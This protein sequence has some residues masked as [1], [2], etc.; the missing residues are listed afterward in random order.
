LSTPSADSNG[1]LHLPDRLLAVRRAAGAADLDGFLVCDRADVRYLS[2]F[3]GSSG[4]LLVGRDVA[5]LITDARYTE[6]AV[7][8]SPGWTSVIVSGS[9]AAG[10]CDQFP[11]TVRLGVDPS[12]ISLALWNQIEAVERVRWVQGASPVRALRLCK[13]ATEIDAIRAAVTLAERALVQWLPGLRSGITEQEAAAD[14]DYTCR[15]LGATGMAFETIVA[16]GARGALPHARPGGSRLRAGDRVVVDFGCVVD[17]YCSD[18]T[19]SLI[20]GPA[21]DAE[22]A[23]VHAAVDGARAAAIRAIAPGAATRAVDAAAR[24]VLSEAGLAT[25]FTHSL[26]HGV[27]LEVHEGPRL[28]TGSEDVLCTGMVVT[29]EPGVYLPGRGGIRLEDMVLVSAD[30]ADRLNELPTDAMHIATA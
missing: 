4:W 6:Q 19:R 17:G 2:G 18:M 20:V 25:Y 14:L 1:R 10:L 13:D 28:A 5:V 7:L 16:S 12:A 26:G 27:G 21:A 22:W 8:E 30:G 29:V 23:T 15:R 11:A 9:L 24:D 3:S